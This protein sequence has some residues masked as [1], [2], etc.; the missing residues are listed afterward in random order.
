MTTAAAAEAAEGEGARPPAERRP[1]PATDDDRRRGRPPDRGP[2]RPPIGGGAGRVTPGYAAAV[3]DRLPPPGPSFLREQP[4]RV[5]DRTFRA[6]MSRPSEA[7]DGWWLAI[8]WVVDD[9]GVVRFADVA[10]AAGRR[11]I[12]RSAGLGR[13]SAARCPG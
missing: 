3:P 2:R 13:P 4:V 11:P 9:D 5:G 8:L 10:P 6:G 12:R 1:P 7:P